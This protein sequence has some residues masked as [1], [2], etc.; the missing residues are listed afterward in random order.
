MDP[1]YP[2]DDASVS[3]VLSGNSILMFRTTS[4]TD[5]SYCHPYG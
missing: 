1:G 2:I 5:R 3:P 4:V